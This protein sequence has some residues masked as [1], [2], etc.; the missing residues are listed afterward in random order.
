VHQSWVVAFIS[1]V[2]ATDKY[3]LKETD[4][5]AMLVFVDNYC[6]ANPLE[7]IAAAAET[8]VYELKK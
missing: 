7:D 1:G 5:D 4:S 8:L 6:Q 3:T 2:G